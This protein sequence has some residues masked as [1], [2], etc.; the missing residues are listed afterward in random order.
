MNKPDI[1]PAPWQTN[2]KGE[3]FRWGNGPETKGYY[4]RIAKVSIWKDNKSMGSANA[5]A[6]KAVPEMINAL[7]EA[8][9]FIDAVADPSVKYD[10]ECKIEI[11]N[12]LEKAGVE[13]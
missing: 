10:Q 2:G 3:V 11:E 9:H 6:I 12:A 7:M 5:E 4:P 8:K 1:T 13:L